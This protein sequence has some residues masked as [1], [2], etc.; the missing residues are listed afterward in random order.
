MKLARELHR[1]GFKFAIGDFGTGYASL[2]M[3]SVVLGDILKIDKS[4]LESCSYIL[5][6]VR[7]YAKLI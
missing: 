2:D 4:L 3:L 1:K 6:I 5:T 7:S